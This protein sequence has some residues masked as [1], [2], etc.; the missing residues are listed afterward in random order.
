MNV[1]LDIQLINLKIKYFFLSLLKFA[2]FVPLLPIPFLIAI[3][4]C[5]SRITGEKLKEVK[6]KMN[7]CALNAY[8]LWKDIK[9]NHFANRNH[10]VPSNWFHRVDFKGNS[11]Y[12]S[13][14]FFFSLYFTFNFAHLLGRFF[15]RVCVCVLCDIPQWLLIFFRS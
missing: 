7:I 6:K 2:S 14:T 1:L 12:F 9:K 15:L 3:A 10:A 11:F 5:I 13:L 8:R 4:P